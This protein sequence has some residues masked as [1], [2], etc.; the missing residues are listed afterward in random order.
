MAS[1]RQ[2]QDNGQRDGNSNWVGAHRPAIINLGQPGLRALRHD[3][4]LTLLPNNGK[5]SN[6]HH[7]GL[8]DQSRVHSVIPISPGENLEPPSADASELT[9]ALLLSIRTL[10][11]WNYCIPRGQPTLQSRS[12]RQCQRWRF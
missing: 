7:G 3:S 8:E 11:S 5:F 10:A 9:K 2:Q 1:G 6:P 4:G 12:C